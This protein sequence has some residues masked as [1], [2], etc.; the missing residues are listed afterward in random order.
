MPTI[1][2]HIGNREYRLDYDRTDL[3]SG[4]M[5]KGTLYMDRILD[6][7]FE[8][9]EEGDERLFGPSGTPEEVKKPVMRAILG[10]ELRK[11]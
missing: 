5:Y 9:S 2:C 1:H 4:S 8:I 10:E 6:F 7:F 11:M 3:V